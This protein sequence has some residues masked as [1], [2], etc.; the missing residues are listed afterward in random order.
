MT[1]TRLIQGNWFD[2]TIDLQLVTFTAYPGGTVDKVTEDFIATNPIT[3]ILSDGARRYV[4]KDLVADGNRLTITDMG[5]LHAGTYNLELLTRTDDGKPLRYKEIAAI[6]V[7]DVTAMGRIGKGAEFAIEH[8]VLDAATFVSIK[9]E[10][11]DT[12]YIGQNGNWWV[13]DHDTGVR[14]D[15]M[16]QETDPSVPAHVKAITQEDIDKWNEGS[17]GYDVTYAS[18]NLIFGGNGKQPTFSNGNL[19]L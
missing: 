15:V 2:L 3:A 6:S 11:G 14:P 8:V 1:A 12:P 13:G 10:P 18:G 7:V 9:G 16:G 5:M 17:D 4:Y 19:I